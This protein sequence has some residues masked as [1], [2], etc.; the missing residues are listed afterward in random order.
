MY[1][2]FT[3]SQ[4]SLIYS[5]GYHACVNFAIIPDSFGLIM[6]NLLC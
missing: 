5:A 3:D 4:I 2:L 1:L 6:K